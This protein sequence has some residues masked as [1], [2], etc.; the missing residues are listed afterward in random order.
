MKMYFKVIFIFLF[1]ASCSGKTKIPPGVMGPEKMEKVLWDVFMADV[2]AQQ[3]SGNDTT[4]VLSDKIKELSEESF[5]VNK[6]K[7]KDFFNS[8]NWY[9][10]HPEIFNQ[11]LDSIYSR[12]SHERDRNLPDKSLPKEKLKDSIEQIQKSGYENKDIK[13]Q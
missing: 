9:I 2:A 1:M 11:L 5:R 4:V 12:Q 13:G 10:K 8:Y 7:E 6:I 3:I